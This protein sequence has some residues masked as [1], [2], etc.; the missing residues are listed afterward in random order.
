MSPPDDTNAPVNWK[1]VRDYDDIRYET[2]GDGIAKITIARPEVRNA[3]R[4][5]TIFELIDAFARA[6]EDASIGVVLFTGEGPDAFCSGGDQKVRGNSGYE[7]DDGVPR[8]NAHD[9]QRIM[10]SFRKPIIALVAGYAV[11]GGQ[12]LHLL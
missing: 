9:L 1:S 12:V 2:S 10:R 11:G 7:D 8:L 5:R 6:R 3:F 4:P